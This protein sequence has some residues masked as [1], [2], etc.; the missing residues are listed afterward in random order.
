MNQLQSTI[1]EHNL[2]LEKPISE[3]LPPS[4]PSIIEPSG[5]PNLILLTPERLEIFPLNDIDNLKIPVIETSLIDPDPKCIKLDTSQHK[6]CKDYKQVQR[7]SECL[8]NIIQALS[9]PV[10]KTCIL[11]SHY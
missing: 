3:H 7:K 6:Y 9:S 11:K 5:N 4:S 1:T 2:G 8:E 10:K